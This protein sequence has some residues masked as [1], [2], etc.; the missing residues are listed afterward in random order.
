MPV[1]VDWERVDNIERRGREVVAVYGADGGRDNGGG[2]FNPYAKK[3]GVEL[4]CCR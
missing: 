4:G 1:L 3:K 2:S